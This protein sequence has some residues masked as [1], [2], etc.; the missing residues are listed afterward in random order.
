MD[1]L[2]GDCKCAREIITKRKRERESERERNWNERRKDK[3]LFKAT[4]SAKVTDLIV[5]QRYWEKEWKWK[6]ERERERERGERERKREIERERASIFK[7]VFF[8]FDPW[9]ELRFAEL[10]I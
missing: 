8:V 10:E 1:W 3:N 6:S 9:L 5:G 2:L 4:G 7:T